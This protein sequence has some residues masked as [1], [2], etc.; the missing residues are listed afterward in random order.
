MPPLHSRPQD[1]DE[2][3]GALGSMRIGA[4]KAA[5]AD[6]PLRGLPPPRGTHKRFD[7]DG[8]TVDSPQRTK[9]RG[10]PAAHGSHKR[11]GDE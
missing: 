1:A 5:G 7:D 11:F 8:A 9:L 4:T 2:L 10:V 3:T 6:V